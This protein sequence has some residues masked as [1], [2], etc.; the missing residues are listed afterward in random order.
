MSQ[1]VIQNISTKVN[2]H[3]PFSPAVTGDVVV[4][5]HGQAL[6]WDGTQ[7]RYDND[8]LV[9]KDLTGV[10]DFRSAGGGALPFTF[11][12]YSVD[13]NQVWE[14]GTTTGAGQVSQA[15]LTFHYPHDAR[16]NTDTFFHL[17]ISTN[18][19]ITTTTSFQV[20]AG[21]A[22]RDTGIFPALKQLAN[23][24]YTFA[25]AG[26]VRRH[27]VVEV[28]LST[29]VATATTLANSEL[30][31]DGILQIYVRYQRGLAPDTMANNSITFLHFADVH[32]QSD[33]GGGTFSRSTPFRT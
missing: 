19:S 11:A 27:I 10:I 13:A 29:A 17:H 1:V 26:D 24:T 4:P 7:S 32:Y 28:P 30:E 14:Y 33:M 15:Y 6:A 25:G 18:I 23:I 22:K 5:V 9:W 8:V 20:W 3:L 12:Q 16:P 21:F 2:T 31:T